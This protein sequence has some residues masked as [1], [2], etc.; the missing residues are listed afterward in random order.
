MQFGVV[1]WVSRGM[2]VLGGVVIVAGE[3]AVMGIFWHM[4]PNWFKLAE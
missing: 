2:G 4:H 1:S 3:G